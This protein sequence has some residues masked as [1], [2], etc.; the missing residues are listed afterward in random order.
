M[1]VENGSALIEITRERRV[2]AVLKPQTRA[3]FAKGEMEI[4][5]DIISPLDVK[6]NALDENYED[7]YFSKDKGLNS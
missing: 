6:W 2:V 5:G 1:S 3:G 4:V 7:P